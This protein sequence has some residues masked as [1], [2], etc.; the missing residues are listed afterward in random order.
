MS[1]IITAPAFNDVF[2]ATKKNS[3]MQ[4]LVTAIY[5]IGSS[6]IFPRTGRAWL[7][8]LG[9]LAGAIFILALGD[10]LGRRRSMMLGGA[11]MILGV[12]I[13]VTAQPGPLAQFII[14]RVITGVGN[15][16]NTSTIP[17]YQGKGLAALSSSERYPC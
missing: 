9:C 16:I 1:G 7:I 4:G 10:F 3:T 15:G 11:T 8:L 13:Q 17:T 2:T 12:I 14:G 6:A 5:E